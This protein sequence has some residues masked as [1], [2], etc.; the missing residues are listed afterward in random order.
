[1]KLVHPLIAATVVALT[2]PTLLP[3]PA[4]AA[5]SMMS[6]APKA[7]TWSV[8]DLVVSGAF[9]RAT[10]P[11]APVGGGYLTITNNGNADDTLVSATSPAAGEVQLHDMAMQDGVMKMR[12][13][14]NGIPVPAGKTVTLGPSGLHLMFM[15]LKEAF[16]KGKSVPV[17]LT[18][19]KA[20]SLAIELAVGDIAA[21]APAGT[22]PGDAVDGMKM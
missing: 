21:K 19:A 7:K 4:A 2:L 13:L 15:S 22:A 11:N 17:T 10:L 14:P 6:M 3:A 5:S 20:G 9:A 18:F 8:A 12:P 16:V 1:M